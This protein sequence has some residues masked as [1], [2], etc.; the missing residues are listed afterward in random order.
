[1]KDEHSKE[2]TEPLTYPGSRRN[3]QHEGRREEWHV[4]H[5]ATH[6]CLR[7]PD[8]LWHSFQRKFLLQF[9]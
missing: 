8:R 5:P 9:P 2:T 4:T 6:V 3:M 1:M 7:A